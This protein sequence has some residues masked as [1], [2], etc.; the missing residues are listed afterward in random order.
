LGPEQLLKM[1][2]EACELNGLSLAEVLAARGPQPGVPLLA[3]GAQPELR[4]P[5]VSGL[6]DLFSPAVGSDAAEPARAGEKP[7]LAP[8]EKGITSPC[9]PSEAGASEEG[10][11]S[12]DGDEQGAAGDLQL[13]DPPDWP[14]K[15]EP[16]SIKPASGGDRPPKRAREEPP[17]AEQEAP[18]AKHAT[19]QAN[20]KSEPEPPALAKSEEKAAVSDGVANSVT[21]PREYKQFLRQIAA[22]HD[23]L[24]DG[25]LQTA[26]KASLFQQFLS[27]DCDLRKVAGSLQK[28]VEKACAPNPF[29]SDTL[30]PCPI[31]SPANGVRACVR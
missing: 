31:P 30:H 19:L 26:G 12:S 24:I 15:E 6:E 16:R 27:A 2:Q 18:A 5:S 3:R 1:F 25:A 13:E 7:P 23:P 29:P 17:A 20:G 8:P 10:A 22:K 21:H 9:S 14:P 28:E 4:S 11:E